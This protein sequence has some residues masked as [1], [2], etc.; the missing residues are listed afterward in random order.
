MSHGYEVESVAKKASGHQEGF[1]RGYWR[2]LLRG[3]EGRRRN[4]GN[5]R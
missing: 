1:M 4:R 2:I 3:P 5:K